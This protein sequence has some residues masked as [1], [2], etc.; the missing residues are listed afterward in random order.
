MRKEVHT[1]KAERRWV[2]W[3][4]GQ[5]LLS[6]VPFSPPPLTSPGKGR[7]GGLFLNCPLW[8]LKWP[9]DLA[10]VCVCVCVRE[11]DRDAQACDFGKIPEPHQA[12]IFPSL[13]WE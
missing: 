7:K 11:R 13:K 12:S 3:A 9:S 5:G 6:L 1:E 8:K 10:T 2:C 4:L